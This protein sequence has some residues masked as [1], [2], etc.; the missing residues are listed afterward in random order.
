MICN[1]GNDENNGNKKLLLLRYSMW[2]HCVCSVHWHNYFQQPGQA[3]RASAQSIFLRCL[4]L[5]LHGRLN[6]QLNQH[7]RRLIKCSEQ[8]F[9]KTSYNNLTIKTTV[10]TY[11]TVPKT[12]LFLS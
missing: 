1:E 11:K 3:V 12:L 10:L 9:A 4:W 8:Q 5:Q 7:K 6:G 2:R